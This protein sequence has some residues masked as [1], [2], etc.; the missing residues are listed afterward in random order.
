MLAKFPDHQ[1]T[2]FGCL[3]SPKHG[4]YRAW[5]KELGQMGGSKIERKRKRK[6]NQNLKG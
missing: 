1:N 2:G 6:K 5:I 4:S 3:H